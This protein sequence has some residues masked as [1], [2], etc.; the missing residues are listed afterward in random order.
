MSLVLPESVLSLVGAFSTEEQKEIA[1]LEACFKESNK[2][3]PAVYPWVVD[4]MRSSG[5]PIFMLTFYRANCPSWGIEKYPNL[6]LRMRTIGGEL[7]SKVAFDYSY[8][9]E[10]MKELGLTDKFYSSISKTKNEVDQLSPEEAIKLFVAFAKKEGFYLEGVTPEADKIAFS[11]TPY[12][13]G[14]VVLLAAVGGVYL[15]TRK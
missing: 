7:P 14:G 5:S 10:R 11:Y 8:Y 15:Y 12:V 6:Y 1:A 3:F 4:K 9:V 13:I 2:K